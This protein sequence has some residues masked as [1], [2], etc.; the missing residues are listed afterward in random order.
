[1]DIMGLLYYGIVCGL[2]SWVSPRLGEPPVRVAMGVAVGIA[3]AG[4]LPYLRMMLG[5]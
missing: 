1:M 2:L 4:L 5:A 3:A